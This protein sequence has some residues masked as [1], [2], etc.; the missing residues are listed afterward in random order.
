M[1]AAVGFYTATGVAVFVLRRKYPDVE[2][3]Y[4][5]L[6]YPFTPIL[7]IIGNSLILINSL[8]DRPWETFWGCLLVAAGIPAFIFWKRKKEKQTT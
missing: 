4:R 6:G 1:F 8:W 7:Y 3:P 5:T 2:R